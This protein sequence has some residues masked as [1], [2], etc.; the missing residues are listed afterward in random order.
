MA[1]L[2]AGAAGGRWPV[3]GSTIN[4]TSESI[5]TG[6][7]LTASRSDDKPKLQA[8]V[9]NFTVKVDCISRLNSD[10]VADPLD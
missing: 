5:N 10:N 6:C 8:A 9:A 2:A 7:M 1:T 4:N 3:V